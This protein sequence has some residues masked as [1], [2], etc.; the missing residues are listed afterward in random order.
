MGED[1]VSPWYALVGLD[2]GNYAFFNA[3]SVKSGFCDGGIMCLKV[4]PYYDLIIKH[5]MSEE[6]YNLYVKETK[7]DYSTNSKFGRWGL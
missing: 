7:W 1:G 2:N 4:C 6:D 3:S 5:G